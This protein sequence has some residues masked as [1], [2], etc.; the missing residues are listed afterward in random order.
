MHNRCQR[1]QYHICD[2]IRYAL[3]SVR[4]VAPYVARGLSFPKAKEIYKSRSYMWIYF[5]LLRAFKEHM[6]CNV[7]R[8]RLI[9]C[10]L[11]VPSGSKTSSDSPKHQTLSKTIRL[12]SK[13][14][15]R[16]KIRFYRRPQGLSNVSQHRARGTT[17]L[18]LPTI[19]KIYIE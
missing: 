19:R 8:N 6:L 15:A 11:H 12:F 18:P 3:S 4:L 10:S 16:S 17:R 2:I 14:L 9:S 5:H 13:H 7:V 1:C